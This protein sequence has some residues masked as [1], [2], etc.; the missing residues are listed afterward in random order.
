MNTDVAVKID[1]SE[2]IVEKFP[3]RAA[4]ELAL[5]LMEESEWEPGNEQIVEI[6]LRSIPAALL[7]SAFFATFWKWLDQ[8]DSKICIAG[9][10]DITW[11]TQHDFQQKNIAR[12]TEPWKERIDMT[13]EQ[14]H[15]D[16]VISTS[17]TGSDEEG[18]KIGNCS[19]GATG[20]DVNEHL[21]TVA[22][23]SVAEA[24]KSKPA[25]DSY[26]RGQTI[27]MPEEYENP[28][29]LRELYPE[30]PHDLARY[31]NDAGSVLI[32]EVISYPCPPSEDDMA[33]WARCYGTAVMFPQSTIM[34]RLTPG[35]PTT[36]REGPCWRVSRIP[37]E[38]D[39]GRV[40]MPSL[41]D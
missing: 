36:I 23:Q 26:E 14:G 15:P 3:Q 11:L 16:H 12:W 6:D 7:I 38:D 13:D 25:Q 21:R 35:D 10:E 37:H 31:T 41:F 1:A 22:I 20:V 32:V 5:Y 19:C 30:N 33:E 28:Q 24:R 39:D 9:I 2:I 18:R 4:G 40:T 8:E 17:N 34:V 27:Q 29:K